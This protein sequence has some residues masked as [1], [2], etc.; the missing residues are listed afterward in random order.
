MAIESVTGRP[1]GA[2]NRRSADA[3]VDRFG[4]QINYVD[5]HRVVSNDDTWP[6]TEGCVQATVAVVESLGVGFRVAVF[7]D[8]PSTSMGT[9]AEKKVRPKRYGALPSRSERVA[10]SHAALPI[11]PYLFV[12]LCL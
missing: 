9:I 3:P 10:P 6:T 1:T 11:G 4:V 8:R 5:G 12:Q 2:D 7:D